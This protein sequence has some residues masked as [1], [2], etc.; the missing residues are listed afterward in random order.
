[1][2][3]SPWPVIRWLV[4]AEACI[5]LGCVRAG[6]EL[7]LMAYDRRQDQNKIA[8]FHSQEATRLRHMARDL[9]HRTLV[10]ERLFGSGSDWV[11]GTRLLAQSYEDAAQEHERTAEQHRA[12]VQ[13]GRASQS[14]GPE[15]R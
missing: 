9:G 13:G 14:V 12:L 5:L 8:E 11:E 6:S 4:L 3:R 7:D 1:M 2:M 15:P 10:Y